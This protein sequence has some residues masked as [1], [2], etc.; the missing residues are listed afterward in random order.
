MNELLDYPRPSVTIDCVVF[1]Y[2]CHSISLLLINRKEEPFENMWTLPGGFLYLE[3]TPE[4]GARR[5]LKNKTG[6]HNLYL[7]QL[8][9]FG[10]VTRDPRGRVLSIAYYALVDPRR[11]ELLAG[12]A[13][14]DV[15]WF[16]TTKLPK[17]GF[18]HKDIIKLALNRLK[19]KVTYQPIGFELLDKRFTLT[20]LQFLYECILLRPID[21]RNFRKRLLES[22]LIKSTGEKRTG[23]K[24]RAPELFEFDEQQYRKLVKE[25]FQFKI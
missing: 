10:E 14:N 15:K 16:E 17:T 22:K 21:K 2:D 25:G 1:G 4:E 24:N 18:D 9:T 11:F 3:E 13:A 12:I 5:I 8:Y 20:E 23:L 19:A 7:E 6:L